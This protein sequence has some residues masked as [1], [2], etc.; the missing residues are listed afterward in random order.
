MLKIHLDSE[1][2]GRNILKYVGIH[3]QESQFDYL[4]SWKP[5]TIYSLFISSGHGLR[6]RGGKL[7]VGVE[8]EILHCIVGSGK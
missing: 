4:L 7:R 3:L 6:E 1:S 5:E 2:G 8:T